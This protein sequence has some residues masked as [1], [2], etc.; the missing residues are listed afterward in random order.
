MKVRYRS[1]V[2]TCI[3]SFKE[4]ELRKEKKKTEINWLHTQATQNSE[5][6]RSRGELEHDMNRNIKEK[7]IYLKKRK[8]KDSFIK[9]DY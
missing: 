9:T 6:P 2:K 8:V 4:N 1:F 5:N 3:R 7:N